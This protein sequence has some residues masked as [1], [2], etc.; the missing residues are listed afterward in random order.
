MRIVDKLKAYDL[1]SSIRGFENYFT[2][3]RVDVGIAD[4]IKMWEQY[5]EEIR[6]GKSRKSAYASSYSVLQ[7]TLQILHIQL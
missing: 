4:I 2:Q 5:S 1:I 3:L 6:T 7:V